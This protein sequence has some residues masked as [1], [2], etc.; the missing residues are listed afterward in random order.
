MALAL[1]L[2]GEDLHNDS[3]NE[4]QQQH[5]HNIES[6]A[7]CTFH[8]NRGH[9]GGVGV[10]RAVR[11]ELRV[12]W[13]TNTGGWSSGRRTGPCWCW[14]CSRRSSANG[15]VSPNHAGDGRMAPET[16]PR[17]G[18]QHDLGNR[19]L[20]GTPRVLEAS[21]KSFGMILS[22]FSLD[23]TTVGSIS[24]RAT[25][26]LL[27]PLM[28]PKPSRIVNTRRRTGRPRWTGCCSSR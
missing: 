23:L 9:A 13:L 22:I 2:D 11:A 12:P 1:G 6:A 5:R 26:G 8:R 21:R 10:G 28:V 25:L 15:A 24:R 4:V 16:M 20:L 18:A 27:K 19:A 7:Q 17:E 3:A 14:R